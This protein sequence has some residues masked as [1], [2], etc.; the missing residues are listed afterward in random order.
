MNRQ[1]FIE[2]VIRQI[3]GGQP[4]DDSEITVNLVNTWLDPAIAMA[5]KQNNKDNIAI[6][7]IIY[8]NNSFYT[9]YKGIAITQDEQFTWKVTLPQIPVGIGAN[10]GISTLIIKDSGGQL[11]MPCVPL[12]E[13][14]KTIYRTMRPIPNK[15]LYIYEGKFAY[16]FSTI[17]L[18]P[19]TAS[20]TMISGGDGTDLTSTLNVPSD[21]FPIMIDYIQK[22][23]MIEQA[24]IKDITNDGLDTPAK[25]A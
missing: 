2:M 10:E 22:Q 6:D 23:L 3:Y 16:I 15:V 21:Y 4:N 18:T 5:A 9:T 8:A 12:S 11:S 17:L 14:Q 1:T 24:Q 13:S 25:T 7:G 19:Y 20:V